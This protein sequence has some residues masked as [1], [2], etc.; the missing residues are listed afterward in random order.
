[1]TKTPE[2]AIAAAPVRMTREALYALVWSEPLS[3]VA[4]RIGLSPN[5]LAKVCDRL[6]IPYP[7]RGYWSKGEAERQRLRP[8]LQPGPEGVEG[9]IVI[10]GDRTPSRRER[11]RLA[12]EERREQLLKA[13]AEIVAKEGLHAASMK[14]VARDVGISEAQ[15]HNHFSRRADLLIALARREL[16][17]MNANRA[18]E[19]ARAHDNLT[20]VTLSTLAYLRQVEE[21]G[22]LIQRLLNSPEIRAGLRAEREAQKQVEGRRVTDR[23]EVRYGVPPDFAKGATAVLTAA[24]LRAGRLLAERKIPLEMAERLSVTIVT[25]GNRRIARARDA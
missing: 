17:A 23:L 6:L 4:T 22:V 7:G 20:R 19:V 21:R 3:T 15:A 14:R 25:A 8:F 18:N 13:A 12:P 5:G 24:C 11:T 2:P 1:M 16:E 9:E 10:T